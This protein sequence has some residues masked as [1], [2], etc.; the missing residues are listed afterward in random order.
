MPE[1]LLTATGIKLYG[2]LELGLTLNAPGTGGQLGANNFLANQLN[3][4]G[5]T[6]ARIYGFSYEGHYYDLPM[7]AIFVVHGPGS[8]VDVGA[9][10][11]STVDTSGVITKEWE[12]S[13]RPGTPGSGNK[14]AVVGP[15]DLMM[16]EYDKGDFSLRLDIESGP[17]EQILLATCL[18]G[19]A[20]LTSGSDLRTSG[21]DLRTSGSDLRISGSDLR[22]RR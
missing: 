9:R 1:T 12:F 2:R 22:S 4:K 15:P 3:A 7:P 20:P 17:L 8:P 16:W 13:S 11:R 5:A 18:R 6:L 19:G 10:D 14:A 21:S